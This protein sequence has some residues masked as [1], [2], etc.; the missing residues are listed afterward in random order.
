MLAKLTKD[1]RIISPLLTR[2]IDQ[3]SSA[4]QAYDSG[5][6]VALEEFHEAIRTNLENILNTRKQW[7]S[8]PNQCVELEQSLV[9]YGVHDFAHSY[10]GKETSQNQL[11]RDI[12]NLI[13]LFEPR[14]KR[15]QVS[16]QKNNIAIERSLKLRI[17]AM[18]DLSPHPAEPA[19]FESSMD[20]SKHTFNFVA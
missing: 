6:Y 4:E 13:Q 11:C 20:I 18:V 2:L 12:E 10:Y 3:D 7:L 17:E 8:F 19:V 14:L 1:S 5:R 9:N 15:V 16:V